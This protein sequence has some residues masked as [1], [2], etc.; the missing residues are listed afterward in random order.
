[1]G[2][3]QMRSS[4][5]KHAGSLL[6]VVL[7]SAILALGCGETGATGDTELVVG[8]EQV[9]GQMFPVGVNARTAARAAVERIRN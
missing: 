1:M 7:A 8:D 2:D 4:A 3:P 5:W 9:I 6:L